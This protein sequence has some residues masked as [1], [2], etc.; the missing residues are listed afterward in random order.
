[1]RLI[2]RSPIKVIQ[3]TW[4]YILLIF[5][6]ILVLIICSLIMFEPHHVNFVLQ[7]LIHSP[8]VWLLTLD[9]F[10]LE[11]CS[12]N[13]SLSPSRNFTNFYL[14]M[15]VSVNSV[16][17]LQCKSW[18]FQ[19]FTQ[20]DPTRVLDKLILVQKHVFYLYNPSD[21]A[22]F[23]VFKLQIDCTPKTFTDSVISKYFLTRS[24]LNWNYNST[25][26]TFL[27]QFVL[28]CHILLILMSKN[29]LIFSF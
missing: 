2:M 23:Q 1:M 24:I 7:S 8:V 29:L 28:S 22:I 17:C 18:W 27:K 16:P 25:I 12:V 5:W 4:K 3:I 19:F 14:E 6:V 21:W 11:M 26:S 9:I 20:I 10:H 13:I 15:T